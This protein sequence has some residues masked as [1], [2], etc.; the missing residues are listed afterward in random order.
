LV[1][2]SSGVLPQLDAWILRL[3]RGSRWLFPGQGGGHITVRRVRQIVHQAAEEAGVQRVYGHDKNGRPLYAVSPHTPRHAHAVTALDAGVPLNDLQA[4]LGHS[5]LATTSVYL[6]ANL[7]HRRKSYEPLSPC[8]GRVDLLDKERL[9]NEE[10]KICFVIA[11]IGEEGSDIRRRSDQVLKHII[12]LAAEKCGYETIRADSISEPGMITSQVIQHILDD[13]LVIADITG[14][15]PN[16]FYE[17]AI[18]HA[19]RK[20]IVQIIQ[21]GEHIPFDVAQSRT[22]PVDH[23]DLDSVA[24]CRKEL[25]KQIRSVEKA[26]GNVD[27]PISAAINMQSLRQSENPLEKSSADIIAM[28]QDIRVKI[29]KLDDTR[30]PWSNLAMRLSEVITLCDRLTSILQLSEDEEPNRLQVEEAQ[31]LLKRIHS[32][33]MSPE[34]VLV[35]TASSSMFTPSDMQLTLIEAALGE[36][37]KREGGLGLSIRGR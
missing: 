13:A 16:V 21:T 15:N 2:V 6:N 3:P 18:R 22:I 17:L 5:N 7:E 32:V 36:G 8:E 12:A 24:C 20:P 27:T 10:Q 14:R 34:I 31:M 26:P 4:Q 19:I 28:L 9:E 33:L 25:I 1:V 30:R 35:L 29:E 23:H 11:P 37:L